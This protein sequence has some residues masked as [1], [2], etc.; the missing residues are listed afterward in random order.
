MELCLGRLYEDADAEYVVWKWRPT[1][2]GA[3]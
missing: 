3:R 2:E 1:A